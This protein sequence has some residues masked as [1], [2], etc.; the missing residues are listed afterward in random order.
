[1]LQLPALNKLVTE[2][3]ASG[4]VQPL[5]VTIFP[6]TETEEAFRY[7]ASGTHLRPDPSPSPTPARQIAFLCM[8]HLPSLPARPHAWYSLA[9]GA[10]P[11]QHP[12]SWQ[13]LILPAAQPATV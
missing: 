10:C 6:R 3:L 1:M 4:E 7:M 5:P 12:D 2:G 11:L 9:F 13:L 8:L